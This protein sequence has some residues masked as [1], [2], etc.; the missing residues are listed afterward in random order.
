MKG[1]CLRIQM[2]FASKV[3]KTLVFEV[4]ERNKTVFY[5]FVWRLE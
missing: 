5:A 4:K 3:D 1:K 2:R